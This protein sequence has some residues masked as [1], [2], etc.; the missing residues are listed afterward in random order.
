MAATRYEARGAARE[1]DG[2]TPG[3]TDARVKSVPASN[4]PTFQYPKALVLIGTTIPRSCSA[5]IGPK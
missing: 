1:P 2:G 5:V 3:R 4:S